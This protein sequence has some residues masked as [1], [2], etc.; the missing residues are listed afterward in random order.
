MWAQG[1][2]RVWKRRV[3]SPSTKGT[4]QCRRGRDPGP[5]EGMEQRVWGGWSRSP[6]THLPC[7]ARA[8]GL[9]PVRLPPVHPL[10]GPFSHRRTCAQVKQVGGAKALGQP[11]QPARRQSQCGSRGRP[12]RL[13]LREELSTR[14]C[15]VP[16]HS[17]ALPHAGPARMA[18]Q[19]FPRGQ[20]CTAGRS[21]APGRSKCVPFTPKS[22]ATHS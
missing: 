14:G 6:T 5:G 12:L 11:G 15:Q 19:P 13:A 16:V 21:L 9:S 18:R 7:A 2:T 4:G 3:C 8:H 10:L 20:T 22:N 1:W 17:R